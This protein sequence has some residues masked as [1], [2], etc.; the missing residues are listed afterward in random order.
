[1][2]ENSR[3]LHI[4]LIEDNE[5]DRIAFQRAMKSERLDCDITVCQ[6]AEEAERLLMRPEHPFD[7]VVLDFDLPG[8]NGLDFFKKVRGQQNLPPFVMLTGAGSERL[9]VKSLQAGIHDYVVKDTSLGYLNLLPVVLTGAVRRYTNDQARLAAEAALR[10]A[11]HELELKVRER[12]AD[13]A[14]TVQALEIEIE[15][16]RQTDIA[17]REC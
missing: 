10:K 3:S 9:A 17:L 14:L 16:H 13:L 1:M 2:P 5:H 12:T 6:R 11:H 8:I 7:I 15:Q 4:L